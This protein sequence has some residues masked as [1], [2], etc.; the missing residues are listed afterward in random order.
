MNNISK[1]SYFIVDKFK[2]NVLVN[3]IAYEKTTEMDFNK[4]N[5]YPLVNVDII[6]STI[7][8]NLI[9][10]DYTITIVEAR[11]IEPVMNA[12]KLFG[13]NMIDNLNETHTIAVKFINEISKQQND[14]NIDVVQVTSIQ[15]LKLD[16]GAL[17]GVRFTITISTPNNISSC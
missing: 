3:T 11:D 12:D 15:F 14:L 6:E 5:I 13:T 9:T 17:D 4:E 8:N 1:I 10:I 7:L 16:K 2:S